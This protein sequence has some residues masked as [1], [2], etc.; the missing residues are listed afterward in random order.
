M[1]AHDRLHAATALVRQ[2]QSLPIVEPDSACCSACAR[3][4]GDTPDGAQGIVYQFNT[5]QAKQY[6]CVSCYTLKLGNREVFG[7]ERMAGKSTTPVPAK[8]GMMT[9]CGAVVTA[10]NVLHLAVNAGFMRKIEDGALARRGQVHEMPPLK[11]LLTLYEDGRLGEPSDGFVYVSNFGRKS[12]AVSASLALTTDLAE[13]KQAS[14]QGLSVV[15]LSGLL[16]VYDWLADHGLLDKATKPAFWRP[17]QQA[18]R[19]RVDPDEIRK[20]LGRVPDGEQLLHVLPPDPY[21][22]IGL[23]KMMTM[24][25]EAKA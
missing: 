5:S 14:D 12:L 17:I 4:W 24:I 15:N 7:I 22:R 1:N 16:R 8:M 21:D 3:P 11:L 13:L 9:G 19:G 10:D 6:L 2:G 23:D 25:R 18:A 20:W